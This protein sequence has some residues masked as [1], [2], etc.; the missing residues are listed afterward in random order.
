M[1]RFFKRT[2]DMKNQEK[3]NIKKNNKLKVAD[4]GVSTITK[5]QF[6]KAVHEFEKIEISNENQVGTEFD[7][8]FKSIR[9]NVASDLQISAIHRFMGLIEGG[10]LEF[11][12]GFNR[13]VSFHTGLYACI[14]STK[15]ELVIETCF[16]IA[17]IAEKIKS[18]FDSIGDYLK[19]LAFQV[20]NEVQIVSDCCKYA[21]DTIIENC[22]S[23]KFID[24]IYSICF[25]KGPKQK[26][27]MINNLGKIIQLWPLSIINA[28]LNKIVTLLNKLLLEEVSPITRKYTKIAACT[29]T[30]LFPER[31]E[32]FFG[33]LPDKLRLSIQDEEPL[34]EVDENDRLVIKRNENI[35][36]KKEK[37]KAPQKKQKKV[38]FA[39]LA[40]KVNCNSSKPDDENNNHNNDNS[41]QNQ[42][43]QLEFYM[44]RLKKTSAE[45]YEERK[46]DFKNARPKLKPFQPY[47]KPYEVK[48]P[49]RNKKR[50]N[51]LQ[52]NAPEEMSID[53]SKHLTDQQK[54]NLK[55]KKE[56]NLQQK[57][58]N[59]R[60]ASNEHIQSSPSKE[61][62]SNPPIKETQ[63]QNNQKRNLIKNEVTQ[64]KKEIKIE[65]SIKRKA[66]LN[67]SGPKKDNEKKVEKNNQYRSPPRLTPKL[68]PKTNKPIEAKIIEME[69]G[70]EEE[71]LSEIQEK[72]NDIPLYYLI[73][74]KQL[75]FCMNLNSFSIFSTAIS[76]FVDLLS[77]ISFNDYLTDIVSTLFKKLNETDNPRIQSHAL[78]ALNELPNHYDALFLLQ[79]CCEQISS[80]HLLKYTYSLL[81]QVSEENKEAEIDYSFNKYLCKIAFSCY[82]IKPIKSMHMSGFIIKK[83]FKISPEAVIDMGNSLDDQNLKEFSDFASIYIP[84]VKFRSILIKIPQI[85][86]YNSN[87]IEWQRKIEE[88]ARNMKHEYWESNRIPLYTEINKA[89]ILQKDGDPDRTLRVIQSLFSFYGFNDFQSV[90][91]GLIANIRSE[92][93]Q[94][95][96]FE[97]IDNL[98]N[99]SINI[100]DFLTA[101]Q[102]LIE[103]ES[104]ARDSID[105]ES[106]VFKKISNPEEIVIAN[107]DKMVESLRIALQMNK[108]E[109]RKAAVSCFS[110]F[111]KILGKDLMM[112]Y[113]A[114]LPKANRDLILLYCAKK[115]II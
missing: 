106:K 108:I 16:L 65:K 92:I 102:P 58:K 15:S 14:T 77:K 114:I 85:E 113:I 45:F 44:E 59:N 47:Y 52:R 57:T 66:E 62:I 24:V 50:G 97:I 112:K 104:Y 82:N 8:I 83:L 78:Y 60:K 99:K 13:L 1:K 34:T 55:K 31:E 73:S 90:L 6:Q 87:I 22:P 56:Q 74:P 30:Q 75:L 101:L 46:K 36:S 72:M 18:D 89:L 28:N 38:I 39:N 110:E 43:N 7:Y 20:A 35:T 11:S 91:V 5:E 40:E 79:I 49:Q 111:F 96:F 69:E 21:I 4:S 10:I 33:K 71:F 32:E 61:E 100:D 37:A 68:S 67:Q 26:T 84:N 115:N 63:N 51:F 70:K 42:S 93:A 19:P 2:Q 48:K 81:Q 17:L 12:A 109:I 86:S 105:I 64:S 9:R 98:N 23:N 27:V 88:I 41:E 54:E 95:I 80:Y 107:I 76:I 53:D 94:D 103:N 3:S 25:D 29:L